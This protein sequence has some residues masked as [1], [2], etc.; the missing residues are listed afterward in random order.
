MTLLSD[1]FLWLA[2]VRITLILV[3]YL[4]AEAVGD[5]LKANGIRAEVDGR[6]EKI[7][8]RIREAQMQKVPYM[9][10]VGEQE[11]SAGKVAVRTRKDGDLGVWEREALL[12]R[13]QEEIAQKR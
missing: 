3:L 2:A 7:G 9:V 5:W 10:V 12:Q 11:A 6:N 13:M 8:Y 1:F 4:V